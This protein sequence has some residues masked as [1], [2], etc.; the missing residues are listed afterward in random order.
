MM[1]LTSLMGCD[2]VTCIHS[3]REFQVALGLPND[4]VTLCDINYVYQVVLE[5]QLFETHAHIHVVDSMR[6][7]VFLMSVCNCVLVEQWFRTYF[8]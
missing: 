5:T 2:I 4:R 1:F 3:H 7:K 6:H 8:L